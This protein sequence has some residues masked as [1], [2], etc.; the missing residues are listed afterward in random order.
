MLKQNLSPLKPSESP[1]I[2]HLV[3]SSDGPTNPNSG[4]SDRKVEGGST[5]L[6]MC[7][8]SLESMHKSLNA[9]LEELCVTPVS[10]PRSKK[11]TSN[12]KLRSS[13]PS[14]H[15]PT[16]LKTLEVASTGIVRDFDRFWRTSTLE[17]SR[18]LWLPTK[19]DC[20]G[21]GWN[22]SS[23]SLKNPMWNSWFSIKMEHS[24][25]QTKNSQ[26]ISLQSQPCSPHEH[27]D[28]GLDTSGNNGLIR[29]RKV[30]VYPTP[31]QRTTLKKWFGIA[32]WVYNRCVHEVRNNACGINLKALRDRIINKDTYAY[33]HQC[34]WHLDYNYDL[35]NEVI[36]DF[37]KNYKS[38]FA[39]FK[40]DKKPFTLAF[41]R[42][43]DPR[44][45]SISVEKKHWNHRTG[46]YSD[47]FTSNRARLNSSEPLPR[48]LEYGGRLVRTPLNTYFFV[49][50]ESV[51]M[52]PK[53]AHHVIAIDPGVRTFLTGYDPS[54]HIVSI[55]DQSWLHLK[56]LLKKQSALQS[57]TVKGTH[58]QRRMRKRALT[59]HRARVQH[60][61]DDF[62]WRA[63]KW[64]CE[65]YS[66]IYIP[67][68]DFHQCTKLKKHPKRALVA[69][70]MCEF[71]DRLEAC[72]RS[73]PSC[74]I[75]VVS[76][77]HTSKTCTSCGSYKS[78]LGGT[79]VYDCSACGWHADRDV[80]A[81]RNIYLRATQRVV[82][83]PSPGT[84]VLQP[85]EGSVINI[86]MGHV[87]FSQNT[88]DVHL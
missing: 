34:H 54:G 3:H 39:K 12:G 18:K 59:R 44:P 1:M 76:E 14:S 16:S 7:K 53:L 66:T 79:K 8:P 33:Y 56:R 84:S 85:A 57:K 75:H 9:P 40:K 74:T 55:G 72:A 82:L 88:H 23:G 67:K 42:K 11:R 87:H 70:R 60:L 15:T 78:D 71:V 20:V 24:Q 58:N 21:S 28:S 52:K 86:S 38:N 29:A 5:T 69:L 43:N 19:T 22:S 41:K 10:A 68:L 80:N 61:V 81:A 17:Q 77:A 30:K 13:K 25:T 62:H 6:G 27:T 51:L 31:L 36:R 65:H 48:T 26:K 45:A 50:N 73:Y 83:G 35:K 46:F 4:T 37:V 32:R 49:I 2:S 63:C 64:L 47:L